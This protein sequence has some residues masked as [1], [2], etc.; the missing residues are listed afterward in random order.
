MLAIWLLLISLASRIAFSQTSVHTDVSSEKAPV[1]YVRDVRP[2]FLG[3]CYSCHNAQTRYLP[4]WSDYKV[5]FQY[6]HE[7]KRRVWNSWQGQY[8]KQSMPVENSPQY[9]AMTEADRRIIKAW[10]ESGA[11]YGTP[12]PGEH[13]VSKRESI[14]FG[15]Q[16]FTMACLPCHQAN[17]QGIPEKFPP[18]AASD[19]LNADRNRAIKILLDGRQ[20][21]L[22][23][24]GH[25]FNNT[26][27]RFPLTDEEIANV[28]TYVYN[29]FGNSGGQ[30]TPDEVKTLRVQ[31]TKSPPEGK[32][33]VVQKPGPWE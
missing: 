4:N 33:F 3:K 1:T 11:V 16:L 28:L 10:V 7:I 22:V 20:G 13:A 5:A 18:L 26:M 12:A 15:R 2:I 25:T 14:E 29:S 21:E 27:P 24:N 9:L 8:F 17:G 23:V 19:F 6:R 32:G 30:V 31:K